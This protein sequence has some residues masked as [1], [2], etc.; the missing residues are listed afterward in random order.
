MLFKMLLI[1][2]IGSYAPT[3]IKNLIAD[4]CN[5]RAKYS[6]HGEGN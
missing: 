5:F 6:Q 2:D 3:L 4:Q 1:S